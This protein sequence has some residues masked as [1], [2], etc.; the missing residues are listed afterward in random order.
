MGNHPFVEAEQPKP[1]RRKDGH[2]RQLLLR[3]VPANEVNLH[4]SR[5][6][7][8]AGRSS[9]CPAHRHVQEREDTLV[10]RP[11]VS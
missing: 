9:K 5:I 7:Q 1:L 6:A 10:E 2:R 11:R 3:R 4:G 8:A